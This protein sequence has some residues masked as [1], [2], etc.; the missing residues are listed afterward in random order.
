MLCLRLTCVS[1]RIIPCHVSRD[2]QVQEALSKASLDEAPFG[3]LDLCKEGFGESKALRILDDYLSMSEV[4]FARYVVGIRRLCPAVVV[5]LD[6]VLVW[7]VL[8]GLG[9]YW[10]GVC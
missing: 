9:F 6:Y 8:G 7:G 4:D 2:R 1:C 5:C 10:A 3:A